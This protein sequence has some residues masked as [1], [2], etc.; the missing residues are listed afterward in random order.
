MSRARVHA[1]CFRPKEAVAKAQQLQERVKVLEEQIEGAIRE[2]ME[3]DAQCAQLLRENARLQ[4]E[5]ARLRTAI[6]TGLA[7][8]SSQHPG[9]WGPDITMV[10]GLREALDG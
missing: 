1:P 3:S 5:N 6:Q 4:A 7:D 8:A 2:R 10:A 9:G